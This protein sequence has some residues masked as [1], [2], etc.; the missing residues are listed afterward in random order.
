MTFPP[1]T[2]N[3]NGSHDVNL[4]AIFIMFEA[5]S[6]KLGGAL[7][8][9]RGQNR[10]TEDNI[11]Q[12]LQDVRLALLEAD[13]NYKVVQAFLKAVQE[14][15]LGEEVPGGVNAGQHFIKIVSDE[16]AEMMAR[17]QLTLTVHMMLI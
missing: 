1:R 12:S 14:R 10:L 16:L 17:V 11:A 5:L 2:I 15:A 8:K 3:V 6:D 4:I 7:R 9:I 13:V